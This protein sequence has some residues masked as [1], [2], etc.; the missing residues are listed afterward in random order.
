MSTRK[1]AAGD[2]LLDPLRVGPPIQPARD[3]V[4]HVEDAIGQTRILDHEGA[5]D[6]SGGASRIVANQPDSSRQRLTV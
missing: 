5:A 6:H 3:L 1:T 2:R 4:G